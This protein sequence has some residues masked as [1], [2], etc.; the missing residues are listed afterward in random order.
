LLIERDYSKDR[1]FVDYLYKDDKL[2]DLAISALFARA[3]MFY[4]NKLGDL[5]YNDVKDFTSG[6]IDTKILIQLFNDTFDDI[7]RKAVI[8]QIKKVIQDKK[9]QEDPDY[10]KKQIEKGE[11]DNIQRVISDYPQLSREDILDKDGK[12][13]PMDI[14]FKILA[15]KKWQEKADLSVWN[16][17]KITHW[18]NG[19]GDEMFEKAYKI[20]GGGQKN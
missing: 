3:K 15:K 14:N 11:Q 6:K 1:E 10:R 7:S 5:V 19:R 4:K 20:L 18:F 16:N 12:L 9:D 17:L 2:T 8:Q 13:R